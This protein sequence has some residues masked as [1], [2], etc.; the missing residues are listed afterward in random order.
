MIV[1]VNYVAFV[2]LSPVERLPN[3]F[4]YSKEITKAVHEKQNL[5]H[6]DLLV[7]IQL[8]EEPPSKK[9]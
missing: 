6:P 4:I 3:Q 5:R 1:C 2:M 8:H 7:Y 9:I